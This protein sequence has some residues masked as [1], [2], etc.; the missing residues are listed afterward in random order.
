MSMP[1]LSAAS[2]A[3]KVAD[4]N[5]CQLQ[6]PTLC[7]AHRPTAARARHPVRPRRHWPRE[8]APHL[9]WARL[10]V[11]ELPR[12]PCPCTLLPCTSLL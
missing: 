6:H 2:M 3:A 11:A 12:L 4:E 9:P 8:W 1:E 5:D 10:V 7:R